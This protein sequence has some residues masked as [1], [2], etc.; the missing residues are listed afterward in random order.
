MR[1]G[2]RG[3]IV[4]PEESDPRE[5]NTVPV[6]GVVVGLVVVGWLW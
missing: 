1:R 5:R 4:A 6:P 2:G 3:G